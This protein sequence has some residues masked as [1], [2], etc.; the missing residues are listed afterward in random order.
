VTESPAEHRHPPR[1]A[2]VILDVEFDDGL[3][4]LVLENA[5]SRPAHG[6]RVR[7]EEPLRGLGGERR[8]DRLR[9][10]RQ[11][12]FL[13]PRRRIRIL[14]DRSSLYFARKEP[15]QVEAKITWRDDEGARRS[16]TIR[17]DL[18]AYRDFPYLE[19]PRDAPAP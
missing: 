14:L 18:D 2:D 11:L 12:E 19:V 17:H 15:T 9:V 7:F 3:L 10:F 8:I 4:F 13:G 5:G 1:E 16:R 6:V